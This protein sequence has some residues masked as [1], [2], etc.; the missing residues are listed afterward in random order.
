MYDGFEQRLFQE[1]QMVRYL[2]TDVLLSIHLF[3]Q[4]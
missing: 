3:I 1:S 2:Y 4:H